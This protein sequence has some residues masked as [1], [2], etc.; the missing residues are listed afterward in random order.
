MLSNGNRKKIICRPLKPVKAMNK[1]IL[2]DL[3][4]RRDKKRRR[5]LYRLYQQ[6]I[7]SEMSAFYI[8]DIICK[9]L[10]REGIIQAEDIKFCRYH[11]KKRQFKP[12]DKP[13]GNLP[14]P[15]LKNSPPTPLKENVGWTDPDKIDLQEN[16]IVKSKFSKQP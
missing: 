12:M 15:P 5:I 11:F 10:G 9:Q 6:W 8:A 3:F 2:I 16:L 14:V 4:D 13:P 1:E 7:E